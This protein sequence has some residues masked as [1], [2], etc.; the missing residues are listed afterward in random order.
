LAAGANSRKG[1]NIIRRVNFPPGSNSATLEN[2]VIR[3]ER[4]EYVLGARAGQQMTVHISSVEDNAVFRIELHESG[5]WVAGTGRRWSGELPKSG[6][7]RIVVSG[8]RGN[9]TYE[10]K[11]TIR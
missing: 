2:S 3:G 11:V 4:D 10:L 7:Y 6:D 8:T 1:A 5:E 9:A